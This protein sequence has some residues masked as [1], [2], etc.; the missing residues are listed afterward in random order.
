MDLPKAPKL[1]RINIGL[2]LGLG[3]GL[4]DHWVHSMD[5]ATIKGIEIEINKIRIILRREEEDKEIE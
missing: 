4:R 5:K 1:D 2:G 3:L